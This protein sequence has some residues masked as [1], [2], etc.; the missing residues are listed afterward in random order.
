MYF[1]YL[2]FNILVLAGPLAFSFEKRIHFIS[3]LRRILLALLPVLLLYV[4]WDSHVAGKHWFFSP[5]ATLSFRLFNLPIEEWLFFLTVPYASLFVWE[6]IRLLVRDK[7]F[8]FFALVQVVLC[9]ALP[10]GIVLFGHGKEYTSLAL[11][12]TGLTAL[13]DR[14]LRTNL[15]L[16]LRTWVYLGII[17]VFLLLCNGFLTALP[18]VM[19]STAHQLDIRI[20]T[21]PIEDFFYGH[22]MVLL[23]TMLYEKLRSTEH[24]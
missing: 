13:L 14:V 6:N 5:T 17:T 9:C 19:Y 8:P 21:I 23:T 20:I 16:H 11:I 18:V 7:V 1:H 24:E 12:V 10:V 4:L 2:L 3:H 22:S 15:L